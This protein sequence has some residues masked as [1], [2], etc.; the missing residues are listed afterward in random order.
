[1][2]INELFDRL[3]PLRY[4]ARS[5]ASLGFGKWIALAFCGSLPRDFVAAQSFAVNQPDSA[6]LSPSKS[7]MRNVA[8][9]SRPSLIG[10]NEYRCFW[11]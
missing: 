3:G 6:L 7:T 2:P 10:M 4:S 5:S 9:F 11:C 8:A 1:M